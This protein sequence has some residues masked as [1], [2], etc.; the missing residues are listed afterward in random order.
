M[1]RAQ[2]MAAQLKKLKSNKSQVNHEPC[3][4]NGGAVD[5]PPYWPSFGLPNRKWMF[6]KLRGQ[7]SAVR[8]V[9]EFSNVGDMSGGM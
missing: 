2:P 5:K 1:N 8:D 7:S 6:W 3:S 9:C 4:A